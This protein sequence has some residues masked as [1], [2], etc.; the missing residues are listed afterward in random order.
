LKVE[1]GIFELLGTRIS[2]AFVSPELIDYDPAKLLAGI[3][4]R[5]RHQ[6]NWPLMLYS[7]DGR[8]YATFQSH[9]FAKRIRREY[10]LDILEIDLERPFY[11]YQDDAPF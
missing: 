11:F 4:E 3:W 9:E 8:A 1:V 5:L 2:A 10:A 6:A 7:S